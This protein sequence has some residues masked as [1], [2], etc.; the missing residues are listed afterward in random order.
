MIRWVNLASNTGHQWG[1]NSEG[2]RLADSDFI[3]YLGHDDLWAPNHLENLVDAM[4]APGVGLVALELR[5][6][7]PELG[8]V[9]VARAGLALR[10]A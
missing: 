2:I 6:R 10:A 3:A 7:P 1:P 4:D 8:P 5:L 9:A